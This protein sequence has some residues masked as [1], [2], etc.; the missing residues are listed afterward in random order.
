MDDF[1]KLQKIEC[2]DFTTKKS[3]KYGCYCCRKIANLARF[4]KFSRKRAKTRLRNSD[5]QKFKNIKNEE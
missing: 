3:H 5:N 4:K 1:R 2:Y